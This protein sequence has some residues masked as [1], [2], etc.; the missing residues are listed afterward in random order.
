MFLL[1][2][3]FDNNQVMF[4][5]VGQNKVPKHIGCWPQKIRKSIAGALPQTDVSSSDLLAAVKAWF[6]WPQVTHGDPM[7]ARRP[8]DRNLTC[9][10]Q[11]SMFLSPQQSENWM[12]HADFN[13][14]IFSNHKKKHQSSSTI[15]WWSKAD[16]PQWPCV[17]GSMLPVRWRWAV[18]PWDQTLSRLVHQHYANCSRRIG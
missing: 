4:N 8:H 18:D 15:L 7:N 16:A 6:A 13:I 5:F 9:V 14:Y 12:Y 10:L 2:Y 3:L 1:L 11:I 17:W